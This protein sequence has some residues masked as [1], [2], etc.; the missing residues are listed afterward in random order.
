MDG[1][2]KLLDEDV[3]IVASPV[4]NR[5]KAIGGICVELL[6][7]NDLTGS[8][9]GVEVI[10][11]VDAVYIIAADDVIDDLAD[12]VTVL[13]QCRI[14]DI[15]SV[16]SFFQAEDGIR[17]HCVT[18][19]QTCALPISMNGSETNGLQNYDDLYADVQIGR[20]HV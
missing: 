3:D 2:A 6:I 15:L 8:R 12:I 17:D 11:H 20:A 10:I 9:V 13:L 7:G 1:F 5:S 4:T 18:G 19:V 16:I 14:E